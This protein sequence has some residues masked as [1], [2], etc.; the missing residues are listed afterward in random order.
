[1]GPVCFIAHYNLPSSG[2]TVRVF[3]NADSVQL[4]RNDTLIAIQGPDSDPTSVKPETSSF[5][6]YPAEDYVPGTLRAVGLRKG[7]EFITHSVTTA[8][9]PAALRLSADFSN[10]PLKAGG[11][12]V[13]F[14]Y[15]TTR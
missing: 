4:F 3:S 13:I 9:P 6:L 10:K 1:M 15:A 5:Y 2:N 14:I 11:S 12:D 8:G 7:A